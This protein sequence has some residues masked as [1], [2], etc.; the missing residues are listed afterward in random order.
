MITSFAPF[1]QQ[2]PEVEFL[3]GDVE[4]I[5]ASSNIQG[6]RLG[7]E[8]SFVEMLRT[9]RMPFPQPGSL[10]KRSA[11]AR[12]GKLDPRWQVVLDR[13]FFLR[14][15]FACKIKYIP[16]TLA[17]FRR[18]PNTKSTA[19]R[20]KWLEEI[21]LMYEEFFE[22]G[23]LPSHIQALKRQT[24]SS[25]YLY[26]ANIASVEKLPILYYVYNFRAFLNNPRILINPIKN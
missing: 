21:P 19:L 8:S 6:L 9:L 18:H 25:A 1:F 20:R 14:L 22:R 11:I 17:R 13:E 4:T 15:S 3:Y 2:K 16:K 7:A 12:V 10:W 5:D 23:D 24:M 26:C